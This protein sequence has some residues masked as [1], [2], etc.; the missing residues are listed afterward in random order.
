[1]PEQMSGLVRLHDL[2]DAQ[3]TVITLREEYLNDIHS[4]GVK[5]A[6]KRICRNRVEQGC[7]RFVIDLSR[8]T[9][10]DSM[11]LAMLVSLNALLKGAR[12]AIAG[13]SPMIRQLLAVTKLDQVFDMYP[14]TDSAVESLSQPA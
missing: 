14:D 10:I 4:E 11:G 13:P 12:L 9:V 6:V 8:V 5:L 1:M 2:D 3:T 7:E